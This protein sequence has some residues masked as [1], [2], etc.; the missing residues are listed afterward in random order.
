LL[1]SG[2]QLDSP[3]LHAGLD[4]PSHVLLAF[5]PASSRQPPSSPVPKQIC[6]EEQSLQVVGFALEF[7]AKLTFGSEVIF[8]LAASQNGHYGVEW[9][10]GRGGIEVRAESSD[11]LIVNF[12]H[13]SGF[14][15]CCRANVIRSIGRLLEGAWLRNELL[16]GNPCDRFGSVQPRIGSYHRPTATN[17]TIC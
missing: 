7:P 12:N 3:R 10:H 2:K 16:V 8:K 15:G 14:E 1:A 9:F 5:G 4:L 17:D 13:F 11:K 6:L